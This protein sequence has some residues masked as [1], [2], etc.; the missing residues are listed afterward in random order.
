MGIRPPREGDDRSRFHSDDPDLDRFF[1]QFAGLNGFI[2]ADA[3]EG[4]VA[5][6]D[7][8]VFV[9]S[10]DRGRAGH[11]KGRVSGAFRDL[12]DFLL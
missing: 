10:R 3:V 6:A 5:A 1:L 9:P 4:R 11:V 7:D 8:D 12:K 2:A